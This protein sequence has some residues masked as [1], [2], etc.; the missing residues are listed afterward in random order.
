MS[1]SELYIY[2]HT[3]VNIPE[4]MHKHKLHKY[5]QNVQINKQDNKY[6][7]C[8]VPDNLGQSSYAVAIALAYFT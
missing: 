3:R 4:W 8:Q 6:S 5:T 7:L 2:E 1:A